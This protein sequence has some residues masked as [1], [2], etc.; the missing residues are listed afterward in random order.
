[1]VNQVFVP[2]DL[3]SQM[4]SFRFHDNA[5]TLGYHFHWVYG[6][7]LLLVPFIPSAKDKLGRA[8]DVV[9]CNINET[10]EADICPDPTESS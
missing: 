1:M 4:T 7:D 2:N 6:W 3:F 8:E 10:T 9:K 5:F